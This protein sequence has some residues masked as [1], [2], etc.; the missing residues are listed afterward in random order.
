MES[1]E[2][3]FHEMFS[4]WT[5]FWMFIQMDEITSRMMHSNPTQE[6]R[7]SMKLFIDICIF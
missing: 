5:N 4:E 7:S 2:L 3:N 6:V 1:S